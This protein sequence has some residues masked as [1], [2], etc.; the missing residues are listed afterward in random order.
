MLLD[1]EKV[2]WPDIEKNVLSN[3]I[4]ALFGDYDR[5]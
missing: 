3:E 2:D 4:I 5:F 1:Q